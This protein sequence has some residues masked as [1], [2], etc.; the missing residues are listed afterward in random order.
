MVEATW[1]DGLALRY[2]SF[3]GPGTSIALDPPGEHVV[4]VRAGRFPIVGDGS[5]VWSFIHIDDAAAPTAVA[6]ERGDP[7]VYN[8]VDDEPA[9]V[10][11]WLPVLAGALDA[12]RPRRVPRWVG[13][14]LAGE[15]ATIM[16]TG[17]RGASNEKAKREL[18]WRPSY[19]S[20]RRGFVEGLGGS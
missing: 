8:I 10:R 13:R 5:G 7:G 18:G 17:V 2:G 14:L 3:Y 20:W 15:V 16:M 1:T 6:I 12:R 19:A 11:E 9:P 4:A